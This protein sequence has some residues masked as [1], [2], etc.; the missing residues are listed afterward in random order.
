MKATIVL[1]VF[2][3][4]CI[5]L[6]YSQDRNAEYEKN[7]PQW[8][9]PLANGIS[10]NGNPPLEWSE[11]KNV[12][13]KIEIPGRGHATPVIWD[14]QIFI[15]TAVPLNPKEEKQAQNQQPQ[16]GRHRG[17][18]FRE[19]KDM[20]KF[21]VFS[22]NR[23]NGKIQWEKTVKEEI[24]E[25]RT[26]E[27]GSWA[28]HSPVTDGKHVYAYFGSRGLFC[29]DMKGSL[30]WERDFGQMQKRMSFGEGSSPVLFQDRIIV[31]W[32]H[33]GDSFI[34]ALDKNT[35]KEVW[36]ID[37]DEATTWSTPYIVEVD[38]KFQVIISATKRIRSYDF[39]SGK[40]IWECGGMTANCIPMPVL[41]GDMIF[42]MSGFRGSALLAIDLSKANGDITDSDAIAWKHNKDTPYTPSPIVLGNYLHFL[43]SNNG[44]LSCFDARDGKVYYSGER[45]ED[46]G[47]VF[48][49][50]VGVKDRIYILGG[51]GLTYVIKPGP[52]FTILAKN[53]LDDN[54][55]ASPA[56]I[57][58][59]LYLRGFKYLYCIAE[60]D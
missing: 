11:N 52:E 32:D 43:R 10:P 26:H 40:L 54:F 23:E 39:S 5:C 25:E 6:V 2:L 42:I 49:S 22:I 29:L 48:T 56:V 47:N 21:V 14:N 37:R 44:V 55:H 31:V 58:N 19:T 46:M 57:G 34:I 53:Q 1:L 15:S 7:W 41:S 28:S 33:E 50:P 8:R 36:K 12:K 60:D 24:P 13:W 3:S 16:Q 51:S 45:M 30:L 38:G 59:N 20:Q 27:F 4:L 9:G 35:G 17:M 18:S